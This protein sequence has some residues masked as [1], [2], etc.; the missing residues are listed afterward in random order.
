[1]KRVLLLLVVVASGWVWLDPSPAR[2]QQGDAALPTPQQ[3]F[4]KHAQ[5]VGGRDA[6]EKLKSRISR[7]TTRVEGMEGTGTFLAYER[8]PNLNSYTITLPNGIVLREGYDGKTPW[9]DNPREGPHDVTGSEAADIRAL[10]DFYE[11]VEIGK[12]YPHPRMV[13][14]QSADGH[15]AYVIEAAPPGGNKRLLYF[16]AETGLRFRMDVFNNA[17]SISPTTVIH[18]EDYREIDGI[19]FPYHLRQE[20]QSTTLVIR[21]T[22]IRHNATV[23]DDQ[24]ARPLSGSPASK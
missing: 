2:G 4:D 23:A 3:I 8:A 19:K 20:F 7:G 14:L 11:D 16:D 22:F 1:M 21:F 6:W 12:V 5:A 13:G 17:L 15:Q 24:L 18:L 10:S 9:E